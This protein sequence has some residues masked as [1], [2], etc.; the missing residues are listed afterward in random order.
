MF[1][2]V[3]DIRAAYTDEMQGTQKL[4]DALTD[5]SLSQSVGDGLRTAGRMAWHIVQ[6]LP[7]MANMAGI[8]MKDEV[9]GKPVPGSA[10]AI[11]DAYRKNSELFLDALKKVKDSDLEIEHDAYGMTWKR[12]FTYFVILMHEAHHR[13]QLIVLM[14]QAGL[15]VPGIYGPSREEWTQHGA[16]E[17]AV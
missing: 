9:A 2:K 4:L 13:G 15:K 16:P 3:D 10:K 5:K 12:G 6:T 11:A 7:D 1:R 8:G 17:P 14:R